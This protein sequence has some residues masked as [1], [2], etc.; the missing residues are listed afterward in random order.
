MK[1]AMMEN[2]AMPEMM[3]AAAPVAEQKATVVDSGYMFIPNSKRINI[4]SS[5]EQRVVLGSSSGR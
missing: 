2:R 1:M 5:E 4:N 3:A